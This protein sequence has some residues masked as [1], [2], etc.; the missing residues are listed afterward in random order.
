M[1]KKNKNSERKTKRRPFTERVR[2]YIVSFTLDKAPILQKKIIY[3][4]NSVFKENL[5]NQK[6]CV[7]VF[8]KFQTSLEHEW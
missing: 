1:D 3:I 8:V 6:R 2:V 5:R 7:T 4:D